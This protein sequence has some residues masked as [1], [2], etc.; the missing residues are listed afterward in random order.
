PAVGFHCH[1]RR[2]A[3]V[4]QWKCFSVM[5]T[6]QELS[7]LGQQSI[8]WKVAMRALLGAHVCSVLLRNEGRHRPWRVSE[9]MKGSIRMGSHANDRPE[10]SK[11]PESTSCPELG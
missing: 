8:I 11:D 2:A 1:S 7:D 6:L 3:F 5:S 10:G 9:S 4:T